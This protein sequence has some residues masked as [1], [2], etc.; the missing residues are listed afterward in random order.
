MVETKFKFFNVGDDYM[1]YSAYP[2]DDNSFELTF[3]Q[4]T[5]TVDK[6]GFVVVTVGKL[7]SFIA[8]NFDVDS[9]ERFRFIV[10]ED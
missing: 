8:S 6:Q 4:I 9:Y 5:K 1:F 7:I 2:I 3:A 10:K